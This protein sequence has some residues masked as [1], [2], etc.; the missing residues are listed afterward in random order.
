MDRAADKH[1]GAGQVTGPMFKT[2][3]EV[4]SYDERW[5]V[6]DPCGDYIEIRK[7]TDGPWEFVTKDGDDTYTITE[8]TVAGLVETL[9]W[10]LEGVACDPM[11]GP[12]PD[13]ECPDCGDRAG[14]PSC[15]AAAQADADAEQARAETDG[16][17]RE[18]D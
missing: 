2:T 5:T 17:E 4:V 16:Y 14:C 6:I 7:H 10:R 8:K 15:V 9:M 13:D 11:E 3:T 12:M 18:Q 1:M